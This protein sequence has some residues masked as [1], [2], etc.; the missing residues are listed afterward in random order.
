MEKSIEN[1][2][3]AQ[4]DSNNDWKNSVTEDVEKLKVF[5]QNVPPEVNK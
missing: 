2:L 3:R 1:Q 5:Q 4:I